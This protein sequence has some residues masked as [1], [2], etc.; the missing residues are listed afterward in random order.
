MEFQTRH[1]RKADSRQLLQIWGQFTDHISDFDKRYEPTEEA[2]DRW[3]P[4][5]ENQ[6]VDSKY[7][8]VIVAENPDVELIGAIEVRVMA[9]HPIFQL[10]EHGYI[11][12]FH[13][14]QGYRNQGVGNALLK[15]MESWLNTPPRQIETVRLDLLEK[16]E[17]S[18][19]FFSDY[20]FETVEQV[21]EKH[22]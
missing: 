10:D 7:G 18:K 14:L 15:D 20:G 2:G 9:S 13:V 4:Y 11:K 21:F 8:T 12:G 22:V 17:S 16:D 1:A 5:F 6:L 19:Q 3:I